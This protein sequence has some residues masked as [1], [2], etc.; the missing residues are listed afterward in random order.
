[1]RRTH[2]KVFPRYRKPSV[3]TLLG[4]T[5]AKRRILTTTGYYAATRPLRAPTNFKRRVLR[6]A[7]YY[8]APMQ[9][10]RFLSHWL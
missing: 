10:A 5:R 7:G 2:Y 3:R 4:V 8:S 9:A 1:M 6:H